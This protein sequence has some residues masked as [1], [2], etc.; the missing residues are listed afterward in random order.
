MDNKDNTKNNKEETIKFF[1][2]NIEKYKLEKLEEY[3]RYYDN[4]YVCMPLFR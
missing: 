1:S 4:E 3:V 2:I